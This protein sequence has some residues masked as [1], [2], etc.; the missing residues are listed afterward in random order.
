M[1]ILKTKN[2]QGCLEGSNVKDIL[3]C[4]IINRDD[5]NQLSE[6]GKLVISEEMEKPFFSIIVRGKY[7]IKGTLG[8]KSIRVVLPKED[9]TD[10]F[11][12]LLEYIK[13]L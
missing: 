10:N 2:I 4:D 12:Q 13:S 6:L 5:I 3:F 8:N 1:E 11:E 9:T 7:T